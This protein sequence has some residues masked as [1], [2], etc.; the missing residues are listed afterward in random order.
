MLAK[1][2]TKV[3]EK[4]MCRR[5][6][7]LWTWECWSAGSCSWSQ[8]RYSSIC[9][10]WTGADTRVWRSGFL[11]W[12]TPSRQGN[13]NTVYIDVASSLETSYTRYSGPVWGLLAPVWLG[14]ECHCLSLQSC[15]TTITALLT[16]VWAVNHVS[17]D[18]Q[19]NKC[20]WWNCVAVRKLIPLFRLQVKIYNI[21]RK[22]ARVL[23]VTAKRLW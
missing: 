21:R 15:R 10:S 18:G 14:L 4:K 9:V 7:Y 6:I 5:V 17:R 13:V 12:R 22:R 11:V 23:G 20:T 16:R 19:T 1:F 2:V 8:A 3:G